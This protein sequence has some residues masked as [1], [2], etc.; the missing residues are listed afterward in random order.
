MPC[1][2]NSCYPTTSEL[3]ERFIIESCKLLE[4]DE[5]KKLYM[6]NKIR[7]ILYD[8]LDGIV[9]EKSSQ[10]KILCSICKLLSKDEMKKVQPFSGMTNLLNWYISHIIDDIKGN[11]GEERIRA[12]KELLRL[13]IDYSINEGGS[14]SYKDSYGI[15]TTSF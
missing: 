9:T 12:K 5:A 6:D 8:R 15:E 4:I 10:I 11:E 1:I 2:D 3:V 13:S 7:S 14:I